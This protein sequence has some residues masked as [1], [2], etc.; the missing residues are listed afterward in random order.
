MRERIRFKPDR[1]PCIQIPGL[2]TGGFLQ[3]LPPDDDEVQPST[4][5]DL[6]TR[7]VAIDGGELHYFQY[8]TGHPVIFVHGS[9]ADYRAW[10]S[11]LPAFSDGY[12]FVTY[13]RRYHYPNRWTAD[14]SESCTRQHG[15]DLAKVITAL[16]IA[17][18]TLV[19][20]SSGGLI[21]LH[22]ALARPELV[23][24]LVLSEPFCLSVLRETP[25]GERE[26]EAYE[27]RFWKPAARAMHDGNTEESM[28]ILCDS[29]LG[30]GTYA[31][32]PPEVKPIVSE[33]ARAQQLEFLNRDYSSA[34]SLED[35]R[36]IRTPTL[37]VEGDK[38]PPMFHFI[39]EALMNALPN[40]S[41]LRIPNVCH[42]APFFA[43]EAF[44]GAVRSF[45]ARYG[46]P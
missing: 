22:T 19:T 33:N 39:N 16:D 11:Q 28:A 2:I 41:K 30:A 32:L 24:S 5:H 46:K 4:P 27:E 1:K 14:G 23:H 17:P 35:A 40:A 21:A 42:V 8:G 34:F 13:S 45:L 38:S 25:D 3:P 43:P 18:A 44:N 7:T 15:E 29:I 20:Q 36:R 6:P 10:F 12:Q 26:W 31:S 9:F 37:I